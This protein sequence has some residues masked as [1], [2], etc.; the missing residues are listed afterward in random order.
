MTA[1]AAPPG[2]FANVFTIG[3]LRALWIRDTNRQLGRGGAGFAFAW[4]L[5][6]FA[7]Y[8]LAG[9]LNEALAQGG[10]SHRVSEVACLLLSTFPFIGARRR[11]KRGV[12]ALNVAQT[13]RPGIATSAAA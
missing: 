3:I 5:M 11:L 6:P 2:F 12:E 1:L 13:V 9:R 8:G 7:Y 4:F 10:S